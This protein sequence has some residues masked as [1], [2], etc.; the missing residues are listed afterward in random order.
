MKVLIIGN[1]FGT[2]SARYLNG[3]SRAEKNEITIVNLYIGGCS[4]YRHYRNMLSEAA[5]YD[6]E[7]NGIS[8]MLKVSLKQGL[9][10]DEWD[11]VVLQQCSPKSG[12]YD[13]Y[14]P[15]LHE[16]CAYVRRL[17][18][19][20][21]LVLNMTWTFAHGCTRFGLTPFETPEEMLPAVINCYEKAAAEERFDLVIPSGKAMARLYTHIGADVYRDGFHA[22]K[23]RTRYMLG[24]LWYMTLTG[25]KLKSD[26]YRDFDEEVTEEELLLTRRTALEI[27]EENGYEIKE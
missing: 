21:R 11:A 12:E 13:T 3:I 2:D 24:C 17:C 1:S 8:T 14:Q 4:L 26:A 6:Y 7:I 25:K 20:A 23:G 5:V 10:L 27:L 9:L 18:P 22:N 15:Y 19:P 16:L